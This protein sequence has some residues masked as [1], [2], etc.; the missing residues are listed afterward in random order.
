[1]L[2]DYPVSFKKTQVTICVGAG[3]VGKT[4]TAG[5][6][7][8]HYAKGGEKTLVITVD[9]ALRLLDALNI[10]E[11]VA[12]PVKINLDHLATG[13]IKGELFAYLP[14]L[15]QEWMDFLRVSIRRSEHVHEIAKNPFYQ[16][17]SDGLPGAFEIICSHILF[18]LMDQDYDR[19]VLD[20]PPS[21]QSLTFF[22]VPKDVR[23]IL[24][25]SVLKTFLNKRGSFLGKL[26]KKLALFS[27]NILERTLERLM[28]SHFLSEFLDF[29]LT[30]DGLYDPMLE[31]VQKMDA[32]LKDK[33]CQYVAVVRPTGASVEDY[34]RLEAGLKKR[35]IVINRIVVNQALMQINQGIL[36][37]EVNQAKNL[38][39]NQTGKI[40]SMLSI[41][42]QQIAFETKLMEYINEVRG[43]KPMHIL[44]IRNPQDKLNFMSDLLDDFSRV[45]P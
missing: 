34:C 37:E 8:I 35:D 24:E 6:L 32:L 5:M 22:D 2:K 12:E 17:V 14:D 31:R 15:R 3:G 28:G 43:N 20:T 13:K 9:P 45:H 18:R 26:T 42:Q 25:H 27:G 38:V 1:L 16:Y 40:E 33:T 29:A 44:F 4:T 7:G 36:A 41:Y 21:S 30:I 11:K 23:E 39:H 10:K 19:I